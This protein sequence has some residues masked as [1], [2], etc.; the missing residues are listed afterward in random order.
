MT[1]SLP[2]REPLLRALIDICGPD[3]ARTAGPGDTVAGRRASYVA[4]PATTDAVVDT[5][6]L[7]RDRGLVVVPRGGGTKIDWGTP[8]PGVDL[9]LDTARLAGIWHHH[10]EESAAEVGSGTPMRAVQ[11][12][13]ALRGQRLAVDPPSQGA[14][15]GGVLAVN[16][17]GPL[18][19]KFG[20]PASQV[21]TVSYV[22]S[23]GAP[24]EM[25]GEWGY[26]G[27]AAISGVL[28]SANLR[29]QPLP[30][31]RRWVGVAV[32]TPLQVH[33]FVEETLAQGLDPSAIEIDLPTPTVPRTTERPP[34]SLAVL[35]EGDPDS[36]TERAG[37]LAVALGPDA[38]ISEIAPR[39]WGRY[40]FGPSDVAL[41]IWVAIGD[42]HA[43]V[44]A[45]S[46]AAGRPVPVRGSAG[47][48][49]VH[50]VLPG[51]LTPDRVEAIL[52]SIRNVL[53]ARGGRAVA[54]A[55]PPGIARHV[56]MASR[57]Y[58]F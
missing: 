42:L 13:L 14:T 19:H 48:G 11:A 18:R 47:I 40:P 35:L 56:D 7:A 36:V 57:R 45:L 58:L 50:A 1:G 38:T 22:D 26:V 52:D 31:A 25:S 10:H 21:N 6:R 5:M 46:D 39:W 16:E 49:S 34:G 3:F 15:V 12:A 4:A 53:I 20:G 33:N 37:R 29:L 24:G 44:Y 17:S 23:G 9:L 27:I 55:A 8:P 43:A 30:A 2:P 41:R 51:S 54:I 32:L 28:V